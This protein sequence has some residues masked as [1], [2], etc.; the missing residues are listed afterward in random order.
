MRIRSSS[1][2]TARPTEDAFSKSTVKSAKNGILG[3]SDGLDL[4]E[5]LVE[6][7]ED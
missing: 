2:F 6:V 4:A 7:E 3:Q 5:E 1:P